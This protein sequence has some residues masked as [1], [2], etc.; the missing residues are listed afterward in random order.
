MRCH[1]Q[2]LPAVLIAALAVGLSMAAI[3]ATV[4][5]TGQSESDLS[6]IVNRARKGDRLPPIPASNVRGDPE[7][8]PLLINLPHA[9]ALGSKLPVGC[10]SVVSS[11]AQSPLAHIAG[12]CLS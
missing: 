10:E 3:G 12:R 5:T 11:I 4:A 2:V 7:D 8:G 1:S 6:T 9:P